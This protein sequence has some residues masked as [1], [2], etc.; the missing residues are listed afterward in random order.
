LLKPKLAG[1]AVILLSFL[2]G[3]TATAQ[4]ISIQIENGSFKVV[5]WSVPRTA[6]ANGW[7]SV[8]VVYAGTGDIPPLLGTYSVE[9]GALAFHPSFPFAPGVRY[10][11]VFRPPGGGAPIERIFDGP[12]RETV[13]RTRVERVYPSGDVLPSNQLRLYIYFSGSMSRGEAGARIHVLDESGKIL[14]GVF[15]PGEELWDPNDQRLTLTLDPGRIKRG[16]TSN[17]KMGPPLAEGKRYTLVIDRD[18]PDARGVP[19]VGGFRKSFRGG[20]AN[21][22]PPDPKDWRVTSPR[23]GTADALV[24][25]F[26]EPMNYPLLQRMVS[27][28]RVSSVSRVSGGQSSVGGTVSVDRQ[29]TRWRLTPHEPWKAGAYQLVVDTGLEDLAGNHIG[30]P[31]DIDV[32]ERVTEHIAAGT[33][34]LP[35]NVR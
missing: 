8:F 26:P 7:P 21:R 11:A 9:S 23:A 28:F 13:P 25:D 31:F 6:P 35:F 34:S 10:R 3:M 17:L 2:R 15:L 14:E 19:M 30:Q 16:L 12:P 4:T 22:R 1:I 27:V 18:W 5:G 32:F 20:P 24:V 33:I 29:E